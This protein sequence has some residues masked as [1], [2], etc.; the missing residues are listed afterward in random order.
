THNTQHKGTN[1]IKLLHGVRPE[2][3]QQYHIAGH[4]VL[5]LVPQDGN[6]DM[7]CIE[8]GVIV[9]DID[10]PGDPKTNAYGIHIGVYNATNK[11]LWLYCHMAENQVSKNQQVNRGDLLGRMG[12][13]GNVQGDHLHLNIKLLD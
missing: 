2:N 10:V 6:R 8:G 5:D 1:L 12:G 11:R 9:S 4:E 13:T 3:Y 7:Y